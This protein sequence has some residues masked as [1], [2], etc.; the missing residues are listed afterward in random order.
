ME[1]FHA[2]AS[3]HQRLA[4]K[5][6]ALGLGLALSAC[7]TGTIYDP[8][9]QAPTTGVFT[10]TALDLAGL[11]KLKQ[12]VPISVFEFPDLTGQHKPSDRVAEF[13][14]AVTQGGLPILIDSM[15]TACASQC[16]KVIE[17]SGLKNLL[18]ERQ[19]IQNT[20]AEHSASPAKLPPLAFAG[21]LIE[22][23]IVGYDTNTMTGGAGARYLGIGGDGKYRV[24]AV[25]V[26]MRLV[27]VQSGEVLAAITTSKT[28][29]SVG[30]QGSA[31]KYV[32]L[33]ALLEIEAGITRN[34]PPQ[35]AVREAIELGTYSIIMEG[36]RAKLWSFAD[37]KA[38]ADA[39]ATYMK[40]KNRSPADNLP[41][42]PDLPTGSI[43]PVAAKK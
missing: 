10:K 38:G 18:Q 5:L 26:S 37:P 32:A 7:G 14:R 27:S 36:V 8:I 4:A 20:R 9:S 25:T 11:P 23:G 41:E 40:R 31:F 34:E 39:L 2:F 19:I 3:K 28:I 21:V 1:I 43:K 22:G 42:A 17:R 24:D 15:K 6:T 13:S 30:A 16:F 35:L 33:D 12:P 29:Y